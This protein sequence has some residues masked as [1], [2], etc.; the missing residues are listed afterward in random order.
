MKEIIQASNEYVYLLR[1]EVFLST[2]ILS[3]ELTRSMPKQLMVCNLHLER[4]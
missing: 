1:I 3:K 2:G 4:F